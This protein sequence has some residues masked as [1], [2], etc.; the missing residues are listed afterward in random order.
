[1]LFE[2]TVAYSLLP[3]LLAMMFL[4]QWWFSAGRQ[5]RHLLRRLGDL[6]GAFLVREAHDAVGVRHVQRVSPTSAMPKGECRPLRKTV[7]TSATP[8]P[9]ASRSSVMR[10]ALGTAAPAFA[11]TLPMIQ[12]LMPFCGLGRLRLVRLGHQHVAVGQHVQ[13]ARVVQAAARQL[14]LPGPARGSACRRAASPWPGRSPVAPGRSKLTDLFLSFT[15]LALQGFGGVLAVVQR[16]LVEKKRWL[17]REEF[18]EDWAVAQIMPGPNVINLSI[19]LGCRYFGWRG[20]SPP[21]PAC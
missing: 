13:P 9:S 14:D 2:P 11:I 8:S 5:R 20:A 17:T 10:L 21:W 7:R 4:V 1:L 16:E 15:W 19:M 3:S 18:I 12:P 6:G